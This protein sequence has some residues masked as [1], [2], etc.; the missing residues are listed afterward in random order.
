MGKREIPVKPAA[1]VKKLAET[2]ESYTFGGAAH[3]VTP[4]DLSQKGYVEEEYLIA[5]EAKIYTWPEE[6]KYASV[7]RENAKYCSRIVVRKPADP[8]KFSG[9]VIVEMFNWARSYDRPIA[10]WS[11]CYEHLMREGDAWVGVTIRGAVIENLKKFD[12][13][14]YAELSYENPIEPEHRMDRPQ[15]NTFHGDVTDP[16]LENGL[17]W[18][19]YSQVGILLRED[20]ERNPLYGYA[21]KTI[22]G[23]GATAGDLA[24]YVAAIDPVSCREDGGP[25][26]DGYLIFM[27]GAPGNVNQYEEK[28]HHLDGRCKFYGKV[29]LMRVYTCK[30]MLG[31]GMHPDWAYMQRRNDSDEAGNYYRSYEIAG[32]GLIL[33]Y[34]HYTEPAHEDV[35]K[36]GLQIR[37]GRTGAA[38]SEEDLNTFEF[39]TRYVLNAQLE[40]L[41]KWIRSGVNPPS[42][43]PY[44]TVGTY[45]A[46][47]LKFDEYGNVMGGVRLPYL[48]VP[49][50]HFKTDATAYPLEK[51][52]LDTLYASHEDYVEK[53]TASAEKC[54]EER[55]LTQHD[56]EEIMEEAENIEF[57]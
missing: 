57:I 9:N 44:E 50:Y 41:K 16:N 28:V 10:V 13:V 27:T 35:A 52:I 48:E 8:A 39:P 22:I 45:P 4:M 21:V 12:P 55:I 1:S 11:N 29:P 36:M 25:I 2:A 51:E 24:T 30:D 56:A 15:S 43:A 20:N 37:N 33:K 17:T 19:F 23:T 3:S 18:D 14:R 38:W 32:T 26:Y 42:C 6:Q 53:V 54:V 47:D 40:N 31:V 49:A 7:E 46:T 5:G 34:V